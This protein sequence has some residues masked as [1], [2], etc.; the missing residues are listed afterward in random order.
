MLRIKKDLLHDM[1]GENSRLLVTLGNGDVW[2]GNNGIEVLNLPDLRE[3]SAIR[4]EVAGHQ[5]AF[6]EY[7]GCAD[8][9]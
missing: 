9:C 8:L 3:F 4:S 6:W 2:S 5:V 7:H 1:L